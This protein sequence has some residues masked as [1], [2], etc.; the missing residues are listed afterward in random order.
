MP[1]PVPTTNQETAKFLLKAVNYVMEHDYGRVPRE[2]HPGTTFSLVEVMPTEEEAKKLTSQ[3]FMLGRGS[4]YFVHANGQIENVEV[5]IDLFKTALADSCVTDLRIALFNFNKAKGQAEKQHKIV[6][7]AKV[8]LSFQQEL[9][10]AALDLAL[11][12]NINKI[13]EKKPEDTAKKRESTKKECMDFIQLIEKS[14]PTEAAAAATA[15]K[16]LSRPFSGL[17]ANRLVEE[18]STFRRPNPSDAYYTTL[19]AGNRLYHGILHAIRVMLAAEKLHDK[20]FMPGVEGYEAN[21]QKVATYFNLTERQLLT[22]DMIAALAHDSGREGGGRDTDRW[23]MLSANNFA[24]FIRSQ[25]LDCDDTLIE[26]L[27][28]AMMHKDHPEKFLLKGQEILKESAK[29]A[30]LSEEDQ[31]NLVKALDCLRLPIHGG[32]LCQIVRVLGNA[33]RSGELSSVGADYADDRTFNPANF[34]AL[35]NAISEEKFE[36]TVQA[37]YEFLIQEFILTAEARMTWRGQLDIRLISNPRTKQVVEISPQVLEK[38]EA[39]R[40]TRPHKDETLQCFRL[41]LLSIQSRMEAFEKETQLTRLDQTLIFLAM[42]ERNIEQVCSSPAE[43]TVLLE[44]CPHLKSMLENRAVLIAQHFPASPL[45]QH[46][47]TSSGH[48]ESDVKK[49]VANFLAGHGMKGYDFTHR[50]GITHEEA[51]EYDGAAAM[52]CA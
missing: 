36:E 10:A 28:R 18:L 46:S 29:F 42:I 22:V 30:T 33:P 20:M 49:A 8:L 27:R 35:V 24:N 9:D 3:F 5:D 25:D 47:V 41:D 6:E 50:N 14:S 40:I 7:N 17:H 19:L 15:E 31:K 16:T 34:E 21:F 11:D 39:K 43:Q 4:L 37:F 38:Y 32:D 48:T 26:I 2:D 44:Q 45:V 52:A 13:N 12:R 23:E 51:Q 1:T